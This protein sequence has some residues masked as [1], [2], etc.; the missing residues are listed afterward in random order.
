M[1][2]QPNQA[3]YSERLLP[4][5]VLHRNAQRSQEAHIL[6]RKRLVAFLPLASRARR[7]FL[8]LVQSNRRFKHQ[9]HIK[10]LLTNILHHS[11]DLRRFGD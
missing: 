6:R 11:R 5:S 10:T 8:N 9:K 7:M 4:R 3:R 2:P 1:L